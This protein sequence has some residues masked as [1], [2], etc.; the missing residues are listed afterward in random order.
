MY[1]NLDNNNRAYLIYCD[2]ANYRHWVKES[3][4]AEKFFSN[5]DKLKSALDELTFIDY[6]YTVP[7]P[8]QE[9]DE[10][11][12]NEQAYYQKFLS[13]SWIK[14]VSDASKL[15]TDKGKANKIKSFF[16]SIE[17]YKNRFS[18]ETQLLIDN[19]KKEQPNYKLHYNSKSQKDEI[20][21]IKT[22]KLLDL[23]N[24][25]MLNLENSKGHYSWFY[26][27]NYILSQL[28]DNEIDIFIVYDLIR[29][30]LAN[31]SNPSRYISLKYNINRSLAKKLCLTAS[32]IVHAHRKI[33]EYNSSNYSQYVVITHSHPC[34]IC[35]KHKNKIYKISDAKIGINFPPFC[36]NNCSTAR[37]YIEGIT[38]INK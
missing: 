19:A 34:P 1:N 20:F 33:T 25:I 3:T 29:L 26:K 38:K 6:A 30:M 32:T 36:N 15:K 35:M 18:S 9:L 12:R 14:T 13:R 21:M 23:Q 4:T 11:C 28:M 7:T 31:S 27:N 2:I 16:N 22:D 17:P 5:Y 8:E 10:L 37:P 24:D